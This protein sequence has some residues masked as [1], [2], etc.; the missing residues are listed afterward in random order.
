ME[1]CFT[2]KKTKKEN[3][4]GRPILTTDETEGR[5]AQNEQKGEGKKKNPKQTHKSRN[6]C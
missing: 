6:D 2:G 4:T 3:A 1:E 5:C